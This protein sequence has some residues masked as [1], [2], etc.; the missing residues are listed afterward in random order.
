MKKIYLG[1]ILCILW[2]CSNQ[3]SDTPM[4]DFPILTGK[5]MGQKEPGMIPEIFAPN[6][7][8]TGMTEINACFSPDYKQFFFSVA[9]AGR[10]YV[11]MS[12]NYTN[13]HWSAPEVASFSGEYSEADPFITADGKWLYYI[14]KRP[15]DSLQTPKTDWDI[16]RV[17]N[18]NGSWSN[19]EHLG[20][21][22]NSASNDVYPTLTKEGT[23]YFSSER[24][25]D[26]KRDLYYAKSQEGVFEPCIRLSDTINAFWE[27][28]VF[29]SPDEDYMI[30]R[31]YGRAAGNGLY[32]TFNRKG[33]WSNPQ[34]MGKE[35]NQTGG[36][37]C[38]MV[39]PDGKYLF[40]TSNRLISSEASDK[41][42]SYQTIKA[43][44]EKSYKNPANGKEDVYWVSID[45]IE[46]FRT[47][48]N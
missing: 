9:I 21:E 19:P 41:K 12:M 36:E 15:I 3:Q 26:K 16:W 35:I 37:F 5:Y 13:D 17:E 47:E 22:I 11:I 24:G 25:A 10:Q 27:G 43:D 8:S 39:D 6:I 14:S 46:Q 2:G 28:D 32:I 40:F 18:I 33:E 38:P 31:T 48:N 4:A 29:I 34:F 30:F 7:V 45:F 20:S 44:F 1:F 42:L 23:I